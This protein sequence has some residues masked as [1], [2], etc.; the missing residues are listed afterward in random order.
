MQAFTQAILPVSS[1]V[2][3]LTVILALLPVLIQVAHQAFAT[4]WNQVCIPV[5]YLVTFNVLSKAIHPAYCQFLL[6]VLHLAL[7]EV[8][9]KVI[10]PTLSQVIFLV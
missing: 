4:G 2:M 5:P 7:F 6:E 3:F 1:Q 9:I 10:H 8:L